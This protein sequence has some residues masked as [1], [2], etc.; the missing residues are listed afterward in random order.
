MDDGELVELEG[1]LVDADKVAV[2]LTEV[3]GK[4]KHVADAFHV[5]D[6]LRTL[7][8]GLDVEVVDTAHVIGG[9]CYLLMLAVGK[10]D[11]VVGRGD[12]GSVSG[13]PREGGLEL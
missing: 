7:A 1:G 4:D 11:E 6:V 9:E 8:H 2:S 12:D 5:A 10:L 13:C 3:A